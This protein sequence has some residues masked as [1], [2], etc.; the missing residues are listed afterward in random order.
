MLAVG[1]FAGITART[2]PSRPRRSEIS[3]AYWVA[4]AAEAPDE[5]MRPARGHSATIVPGPR[6]MAHGASTAAPST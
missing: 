6:H 4:A 2:S 3:S 5:S 1:L